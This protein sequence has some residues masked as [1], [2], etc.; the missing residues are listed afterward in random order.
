MRAGE[1]RHRVD[2]QQK[3]VSQNALGAEV[4]TWQSQK[5]LWAKVWDVKADQSDVSDQQKN[6]VDTKIRVRYRE[7][8]SSTMRVV[9]QGNIYE[10]LGFSNPSGE[11]EYLDCVCRKGLNNG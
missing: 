11:R 7:D 5:R 4:V 9:Y 1:L 10:I 6:V 3:V 2:F 8:L